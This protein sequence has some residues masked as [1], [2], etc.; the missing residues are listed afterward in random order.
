MDRDNWYIIQFYVCAIYRSLQYL[1][2]KQFIDFKKKL[3]YSSFALLLFL[4][5]HLLGGFQS[6]SGNSCYVLLQPV[7]ARRFLTKSMKTSHAIECRKTLPCYFS[8]GDLCKTR[9]GNLAHI[10]YTVINFRHSLSETSRGMNEPSTYLIWSVNSVISYSEMPYNSIGTSSKS[11]HLV[12][13]RSK[14]Q[15]STTLTLKKWSKKP[16]DK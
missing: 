6:G 9:T 14:R 15:K 12:C 16:L 13:K 11:Q 8:I 10:G 4:S 7:V 2:E 1:P 3:G 5:W